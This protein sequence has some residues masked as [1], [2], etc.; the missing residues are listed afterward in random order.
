[1]ADAKDGAQ[2]DMASTTEQRRLARFEA[3]RAKRLLKYAT[4]EAYREKA[5]AVSREIGMRKRAEAR[6]ERIKRNPC[7]AA[8]RPGPG[9]PRRAPPAV[10]IAPETAGPSQDSPGAAPK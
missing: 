2:E 3:A 7:E 9:R 5:K 4:D 8:Q 10:S 6:N 1:M